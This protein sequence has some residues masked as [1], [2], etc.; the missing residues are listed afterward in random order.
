MCQKHSM[1]LFM[2]LLSHN[3]PNLYDNYNLLTQQPQIHP[4]LLASIQ[5]VILNLKQHQ[6]MDSL[7]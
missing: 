2:L 4:L 7:Y 3:N 5:R 1:R 6:P